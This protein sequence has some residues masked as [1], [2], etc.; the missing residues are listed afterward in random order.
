M[1]LFKGYSSMTVWMK[2][3][4]IREGFKF[5]VICDTVS[6]FIFYFVPDSLQEKKKK[7]I[8]EKVIAIAKRLP[9]YCD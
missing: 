8:A 3:K 6:G 4:P 2:M 9:G 5:L 1:K 7:T